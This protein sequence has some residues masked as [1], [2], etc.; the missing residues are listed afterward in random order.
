MPVVARPTPATGA[1]RA[2]L[3]PLRASLQIRTGKR[4]RPRTR[5]KVLAADRGYEAKDLRQRRRERGSRPPRLN[6]GWRRRKPRGRPITREGP[7][8]QAE[9]PCAWFQRTSRRW[10]VRWERL[11]ACCT[12]FLARA[13]IHIWLHR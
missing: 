11:A 3:L 10:A 8:V 1:D 2:Q 13:M 12:A 6:R 4:G 9:R 5:F 7:R